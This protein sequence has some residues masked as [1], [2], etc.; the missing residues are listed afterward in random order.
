MIQHKNRWLG[1]ATKRGI[2]FDR[3]R[4]KIGAPFLPLWPE[5][6]EKRARKGKGKQG[7]SSVKS[8]NQ[9]K[10]GSFSRT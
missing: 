1:G 10:R 4:K 9:A 8:L 3:I 2:F 5:T 7:D 6:V